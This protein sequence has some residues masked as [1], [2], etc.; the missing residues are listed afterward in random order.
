MCMFSAQGD[1]VVNILSDL[2]GFL[3]YENREAILADSQN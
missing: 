3:N 1:T 2:E